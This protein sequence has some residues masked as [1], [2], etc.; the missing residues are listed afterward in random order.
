VVNTGEDYMPSQ[1]L[2]R[3]ASAPLRLIAVRLNIPELNVV[4][5]QPDVIEAVRVSIQAH[6]GRHPDQV[7]TL[8]KLRSGSKLSVAYRRAKPLT[9]D[10]TV[11]AAHCAALTAGLRR[12][13]F[14]TLDDIPDIP[15]LG[16]DLWLVERAAG[17]FY[18]DVIIAPAKA[19]GAHA[20]ITALITQHMREATRTIQL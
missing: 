9:L 7:G 8:V 18:H 3:P 12:L 2:N 6:D 14:D 20:E 4:A 16:A 13:K 11:D 19:S 5:R 17:S 1:P 10:Y 15:W